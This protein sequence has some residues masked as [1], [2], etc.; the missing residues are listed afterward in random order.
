[1][2]RGEIKRYSSY[3]S[4]ESSF[5]TIM[6]QKH[7]KYGLPEIGDDNLLIRALWSVDSSIDLYQEYNYNKQEKRVSNAQY[8]M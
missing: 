4:V 3:D 7:M 1:M 5:S 6:S 8:C 2:A